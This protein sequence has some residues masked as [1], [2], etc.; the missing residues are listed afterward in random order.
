MNNL[1][2]H[3][4][5]SHGHVI[6]GFFVFCLIGMFAVLATTL[7]LVGIRAYRNVNS[8]SVGNSEGQIALSY[9]QNKIHAYDREQGVA[10]KRFD[11]MDVLCL[12]ETIEGETYE[13][14]IYGAAGSLREYFCDQEDEFDAE[15]GE[16]LTDI[17]SLSINAETPK[18]LAVN[19]GQLDGQTHMTHVALRTGEVAAP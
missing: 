9:L 7:T 17:A 13:T 10:L 14:R 8:A 2:R 3:S 18:L 5:A 1:S 11:G 4:R 15:M 16:P 6:S 19:I 12:R